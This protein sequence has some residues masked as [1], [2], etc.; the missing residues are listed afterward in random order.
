MMGSN[1][2]EWSFNFWLYSKI[3]LY[4]SSKSNYMSSTL[5]YDID[6]LSRD[7]VLYEATKTKLHEVAPDI[8]VDDHDQR[9]ASQKLILLKI[10][11]T[12]EQINTRKLFRIKTRNGYIIRWESYAKSFVHLTY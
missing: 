11:E 9:Y 7:L 8:F 10:D 1:P 4:S 6:Q 3:F 5:R 12:G 2:S